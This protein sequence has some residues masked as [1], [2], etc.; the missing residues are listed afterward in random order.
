MIKGIFTKKSNS[1]H[2]LVKN[3]MLDLKAENI[4]EISISISYMSFISLNRMI[5]NYSF[6][7]KTWRNTLQ[8]EKIDEKTMNKFEDLLKQF[9]K[10]YERSNELL[11][12]MRESSDKDIELLE[13]RFNEQSDV[14]INSKNKIE[15]IVSSHVLEVFTVI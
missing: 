7:I 8:F 3:Q 10:S 12:K 15:K 13:G 2:K 14:L 4:S 11:I 6:F 9:K 1:Y 5:D